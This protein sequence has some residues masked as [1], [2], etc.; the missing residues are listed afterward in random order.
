[1]PATRAPDTEILFNDYRLIPVFR[2]T[3]PEQRAEVVDFWLR[4][5]AL[6]NRPIAEQRAFELAYLIRDRQRMLAGVSTAQLA[7]APGPDGQPAYFLRT[8]IRPADRTPGLPQRVIRET[9]QLL[10]RRTPP[11]GPQGAYLVGENPKLKRPG[12]QEQ[13]ARRGWDYLGLNAK[14]LPVWGKPFSRS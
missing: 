1:M 6:K 3:T 14:G 7:P 5:G 10:K 13:L 8:F 12:M 9:W 4:E 2:S 11:D